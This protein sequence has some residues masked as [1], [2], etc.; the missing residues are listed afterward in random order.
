MF[1]FKLLRS[2]LT[3]HVLVWRQMP[4]IGTPAVG[5]KAANT[6]RFK[7][8]FEFQK[9]LVLTTTEDIRHH[10]ACLMIQ[11]F[12]QPPRLFLLPTNDHISSSS[13]SSTF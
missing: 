5:V 6:E 2:S 4:L 7:Q 12:P 13:A 3:H 10:P 11:R 8:G 1:P 9:C